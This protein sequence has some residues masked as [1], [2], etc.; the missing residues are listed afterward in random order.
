MVLPS[1]CKF[2]NGF[3]HLCFPEMSWPFFVVNHRVHLPNTLSWRLQEYSPLTCNANVTHLFS[4]YAIYGCLREFVYTSV[5]GR[6][7][8]KLLV[9][10]NSRNRLQLFHSMCTY[11]LGYT[12]VV[13]CQY[14]YIPIWY[15]DNCGSLLIVQ[16]I[17]DC[18][19]SL[20]CGAYIK[21]HV[22][23]K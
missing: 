5:L 3:V 11:Y 8:H 22:K 19:I 1:S 15:F 12:P 23:L 20:P 13:S 7:N 16:S 4:C 6:L 14:K 21:L 2:S 9:G 17:L 10:K 18:I